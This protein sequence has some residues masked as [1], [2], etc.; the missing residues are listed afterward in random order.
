MR[1][2]ILS[3][4]MPVTSALNICMPPEWL[5]IGMTASVNSM[6]PMPPSHCMS[7]RHRCMPWLMP[8]ML[9]STEAPVVVKPD[10][11]SKKASGTLTA[12]VQNR[13]GSMPKMENTT[14]TMAVSR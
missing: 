4:V 6:I 8:S 5:S 9:S 12:L 7:A 3:W 11:A 2:C 14:H 1:G 13:K 10:I